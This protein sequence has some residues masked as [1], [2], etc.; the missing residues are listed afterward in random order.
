MHKV[1]N[2]RHALEQFV[3]GYQ[4][5]RSRAVCHAADVFGFY[6]N[7]F[8]DS[9]LLR[10]QRSL[11][12]AVLA[13]FVVSDDLFPEETMGPLGLIDDLFIASHVFRNLQR[14]VRPEVLLDAWKGEQELDDVMAEVYRETRAAVGKKTKDVLKLA[15]LS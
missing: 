2:H 9:R 1:P 4:G 8:N 7:L 5:K 13:Y 6:S 12:N 3:Q 10:H 11:V 15:G 14:Q